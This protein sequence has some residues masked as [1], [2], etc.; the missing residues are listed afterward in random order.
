MLVRIRMIYLSI[1]SRIP[2]PPMPSLRPT[3]LNRHLKP[4]DQEMNHLVAIPVSAQLVWLVVIAEHRTT[5]CSSRR[6]GRQSSS[7]GRRK[8]SQAGVSI[9]SIYCSPASSCPSRMRSRFGD[10]LITTSDPEGF[11]NLLSALRLL[12]TH[13]GTKRH[14]SQKLRMSPMPRLRFHLG[15]DGIPGEAT[16]KVE[17]SQTRQLGDDDGQRTQGVDLGSGHEGFSKQPYRD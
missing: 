16:A 8:G 14:L 10:L 13:L 12:S 15:G 1:R 5:L 7:G 17:E 6:H 11:Q 9:P 3:P 2:F 4:P